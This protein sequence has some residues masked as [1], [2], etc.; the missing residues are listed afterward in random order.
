MKIKI[1][2]DEDNTPIGW[3]MKGENKKEIAKLCDIRNLQYF[4][5]DDTAIRYNGRKKSNDKKNNPGILSWVQ[6]RFIS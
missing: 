1:L 5:I 6:Q 4:G 3:S 2:K